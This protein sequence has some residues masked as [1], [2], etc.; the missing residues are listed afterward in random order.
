M[1]E[2]GPC[3]L[4]WGGGG[5]GKVIADLV[6]AL[7]GRVAGFVD[8]DLA[9]LGE[10]VEP[11]GGRVVV[12]QAEF[13][14]ALRSGAPLPMGADSVVVATGEGRLRLSL[15]AQLGPA[16]APVL[17]HPAAMLSPSASVDE[18]SVVLSRAVLNA[19]AVV[20]RG[21]IVNTGAIVEHDCRVGD[22]AHI[23]PGAVLCGGVQV[24]EEAWIGAGS[25]VIPGVRIGRGAMVGAGAVVVR[26][27]ADGAVVA[28]N[29]AKAV[30]SELK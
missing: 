22:G 23:S 26:D 29:P 15:C 20:G 13:Q 4:I 17:I 8:A 11:G 3:I 19:D 25:V 10:R 2:R 27:V 6:R 28:G 30:R 1:A 24:E 7:G 21:V 5:H 12:A 16:L 14:A 9:K 18:G